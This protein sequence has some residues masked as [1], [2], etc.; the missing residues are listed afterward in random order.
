MRIPADQDALR[1][2]DTLIAYEDYTT[3]KRCLDQLMGANPGNPEYHLRLLH[4]M[5][6]FSLPSRFRVQRFKV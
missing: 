2:I 6:Q 5:V 3:A 4:R 1:E